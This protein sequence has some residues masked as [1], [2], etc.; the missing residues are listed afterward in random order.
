MQVRPAAVAGTFYPRE[1][2]ELR[3]QLTQFLG[4]AAHQHGSGP[5]PKAIIAPHAG[6]IYS[7]PVAASAYVRLRHPREPI[8]RVVL[9]GPAHR[10]PLCGIATS[11]ASHFAT[12]LGEVA[13]D[14]ALTTQL[15]ALPQ[16]ALND[17]AHRLEHSLEV[18]LPFLQQLLGEFRLLPLV[19]GKTAP[20]QVAEVI[21][22]CWGGEET[23]VIVSTDLSH[24]HDY[25]EAK[26]IDSVTTQMFEQ[27]RYGELD[28]KRACGVYPVRGLL[29]VLKRRGL[30]LRAIDLR[31]SG[32]T[33]GSRER[34]VGYGAY[35]SP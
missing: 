24:F 6:T 2:G 8:S 17:E 1:P 16:V 35:V 10:V 26:T 31:N 15:L 25:E 13:L 33:A 14:T 20:E 34:V 12:P 5:H 3:S 28:G 11:S 4:A 7:G 23:V 30:K 9:L 29:L 21:D 22:R 32:D 19:V 18:H 27:L